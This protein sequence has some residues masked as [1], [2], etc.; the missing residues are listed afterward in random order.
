MYFGAETE[1]DRVVWM[2]KIS[3]GKSTD[4]GYGRMFHWQKW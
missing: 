2:D 3:Q 4:V 1:Q